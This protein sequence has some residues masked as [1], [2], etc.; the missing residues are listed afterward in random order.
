MADTVQARAAIDS[1]NGY[2]WHHYRIEVSFAIVQRSGTPFSQDVADD[3]SRQEKPSQLTQT[4]TSIQVSV[5]FFH[6]LA[7]S[8]DRTV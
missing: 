8:T 7:P 2:V 6:L 1:L 4:S 5:P 3:A